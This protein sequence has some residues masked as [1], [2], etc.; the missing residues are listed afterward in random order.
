MHIDISNVVTLSFYI[1]FLSIICILLF[2]CG[3]LELNPGPESY[4]EISDVSSDSTATTCSFDLFRSH[5]SLMHLNIQSIK[6][7]IDIIQ[8]TLCD[9]DLLCF[10][11]SWL[12]QN[13]L[14]TEVFLEGFTPPFR[15]D[16][17]DRGGGGVIVYCNDSLYCKRRNDLE[18]KDLECVWIETTIK[19]E[20]YLIGTFYRP[21]NSN[22]NIWDLIEHSIE[23]AVDTR[24]KNLIITGDFNEN[25]FD[26]NINTK[27]RYICNTFNLFQLIREPTSITENSANLIDLLITNNPAIILKSDV[28]EPFL[29]VN[30]RYHCP[31]VAALQTIKHPHNT[32]KRKIWLYE[33]GDY[34]KYR[35]KLS[36]IDWNSI[37]TPANPIDI[38]AQNLTSKLLETASTCIPNKVINIRQGFQR[39][40]RVVINGKESAYIEINAGVPQ[41]SILGPLFFLI[42]INDI[43]LD[44]GCAIKLF[45]DDTS[46]YLIIDHP[47]NAALELNENL[48]KVNNWSKQWLVKFN[49]RKTESLLISRKQNNPVIHPSLYFD[50]IPVVEVTSHKHLGLVFNNRCHWGEHIDY[51]VSKASTKLN[52]LRSLKFDLDRKTLQCM[53]LSFI[54]PVMEYGD[55]IFDNSPDYCKDKLEKI[56]IEAARIITGATKLVSLNKLYT[57]SGFESLETRRKKHKLTEFFKIKSSMTP[58]YLRN[59]LPLQHDQQHSYPTR[60][61]SNYIL[62]HCRTTYHF[63]SFI[64]STISMWNQLPN[65]IKE[66]NTISSFKQKL[67]EY[68]DPHQVP[69]HYYVGTRKGQILHARLRMACSSLNHHLYLKN[70]ENNPYCSCGEI[71]TT[72][73]FLLH[74]Q[75][76]HDLRIELEN[77]LNFPITLNVLLYGD[78]DRDFEFNKH[79]CINVQKF[80]VNTR[81][82]S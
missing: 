11:E 59:L 77:S 80:I 45:A 81:R 25:Q 64:P 71:E 1:A 63:N 35:Y 12:D 78:I 61:S 30:I 2:T 44:I 58:E 16:R 55:I 31:I 6:P 68:Y 76:Y 74:C 42:F 3:D 43:V 39:K 22:N 14:N 40:Q 72:A 37:I 13:T 47:N 17:L 28:I 23:L 73:H 60:N 41:G 53:Y 34:P 70:I 62:P 67:N 36:E 8:G 19:N 79:V 27:I 50:R 29:D 5:I 65:H 7:K 26:R 54:R 46:I 51:V 9:F 15:N 21:P 57:E 32:Y 48:E 20:K 82:F 75:N 10:T 4:S 24:C 38:I 52:V 69:R 18:P 56:N 66:S 49:P 33:K